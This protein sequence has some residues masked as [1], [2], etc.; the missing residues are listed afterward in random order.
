M[1]ETGMRPLLRNTFYTWPFVDEAE[2]RYK[3]GKEK[4]FSAQDI[5]DMTGL[6]SE[7]IDSL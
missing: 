6:P 3:I 2:I 7:D 1:T 5:A 4:G